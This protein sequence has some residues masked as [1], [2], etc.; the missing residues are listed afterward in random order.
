MFVISLLMGFPVSMIYSELGS[1][2]PQTGS[3]ILWSYGIYQ[4]IQQEFD[5][6]R[7]AYNAREL[8]K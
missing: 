8:R 5:R 4:R 3:T 1:I 7:V 2:F 6:E